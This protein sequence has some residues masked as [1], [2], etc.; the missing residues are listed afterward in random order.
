[1]TDLIVT[2]A[3]ILILLVVIYTISQ[4]FF[5]DFF[6]FG[7]RQAK[8]DFPGMADNLGMNYITPH[9]Q[10]EIG[11]IEGKYQGRNVT[12]A[13]DQN[14][15]VFFETFALPKMFLSTKDYQK[16]NFNTRNEVFNS[17]FNTRTTNRNETV[18]H[19]IDSCGAALNF[20]SVFGRRW[21]R[22]LDYFEVSEN[23]IRLSLKYGMNSYVPAKDL[24]RFLLDLNEFATM[25]EEVL[26]GHKTLNS[27]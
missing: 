9:D 19:Q 24:E 21:K 26:V 16:E 7:W 27:P 4:W 12:I 5:Y 10:S 8:R 18:V 1:M 15:L 22:K 13:P 6:G 23:G 14:G 17:F 25:L 11:K 3:V 20:L 2:L